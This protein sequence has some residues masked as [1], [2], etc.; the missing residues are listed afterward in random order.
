MKT[1]GMKQPELKAAA[2]ALGIEIDNDWSVAE[3]RGEV[4]GSLES[5][6]ADGSEA[7]LSFEQMDNATSV[8][9][10]IAMVNGAEKE[11]DESSEPAADFQSEADIELAARKAL[12]EQ[13]DAAAAA[14]MGAVD[15]EG[16]EEVKEGEVP[17]KAPKAK[18]TKTIKI[19]K[20]D[21][22]TDEE[23]RDSI[24]TL[25]TKKGLKEVALLGEMNREELIAKYAEVKSA[26]KGKKDASTPRA[27]RTY[28]PDEVHAIRRARLVDHLAFPVIAAKFSK[29]G[30]GSPMLMRNI[31]VGNLYKDVPMLDY[32]A[33][34][35][36]EGSDA[37]QAQTETEA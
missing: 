13:N 19:G 5:L 8:E 4:D 27:G 24:M 21:D 1:K 9:D 29:E 36:A 7:G 20:W 35:E 34:A 17:A 23:I 16:F 12:Q 18:K 2:I 25:A 22:K 10:L 6:K 15:E 28:T 14:A 37:D 30:S 11:A 31:V 32:V 3:L 26:K 33:L